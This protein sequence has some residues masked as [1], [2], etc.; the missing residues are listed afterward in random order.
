MGRLAREREAE[1]NT[2]VYAYDRFS[3]R[4]STTVTGSETYTT[5]Y[6]YHPNN[7]LLTEEKRG[8]DTVETYRYRYDGNGNQVYREWSRTGPDDGTPPRVGYV[9][10]GF[11]RELATL[12]IR[13]YNG[14]NQMTSLYADGLYLPAG[15]A[16]LR[17]DLRERRGRD[18]RHPPVGR[19]EHRGG[20]RRVGQH[21]SAV[22]SR[23]EPHL[24]G[25]G[26]RGAVLSVQRAWGRGAADGRAGQPAEELPVRRLWQRRE[27]GAAGCEPLPLLRRV[28][29]P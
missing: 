24:P 1:G 6:G 13:G 27:S 26:R 19:A 22:S 8:K 5:T 18:G 2:I 11:R 29:R 15:R 12:E 10:N 3:N 20:G 16:A 9:P 17:Q 7:W 28:L 4:S 23:G 21:H 25:A 14:F